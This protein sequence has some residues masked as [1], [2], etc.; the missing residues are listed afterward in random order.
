MRTFN[1]TWYLRSKLAQ[2]NSLGLTDSDG[3]SYTLETLQAAIESAGYTVEEHYHKFS[4]VEGTS[5]YSNGTFDTA[6]YLASKLAQLNAQ[7]YKT[8][9]GMRTQSKR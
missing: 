6:Y 2:V 1:A 5:A 7:G 9:M 3:N 4:S 8:P